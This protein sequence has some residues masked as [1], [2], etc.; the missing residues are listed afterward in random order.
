MIIEHWGGEK[1]LQGVV[2]LVEPSAFTKVSALGVEEQRVNVIVDIT[3]G[4]EERPTLGDGFR[5][6]VKIVVWSEDDLLRVPTSAIFRDNDGW[7]VFAIRNGKAAKTPI[8]LGRRNVHWAAAR[9]GVAE[10][11]RVILHPSDQIAD[12][13]VVS[14]RDSLD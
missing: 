5:V 14:V 8:E 3:N 11:T 4:V 10:G 2:R 9:N 12:G 6:E 7:N 13:V 1:P